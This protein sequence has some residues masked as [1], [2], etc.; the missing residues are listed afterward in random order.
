MAGGKAVVHDLLLDAHR[1]FLEGQTQ[2]HAHVAALAACGVAASGHAAEERAED[3]A[4][5]AETATEY[6]FEIDVAA[7]VR[8]CATGS[9][10]SCTGA[11]VVCALVGI[12]QDVVRL[13]ELLELLLGVRRL[14]H[15]GMELARLLT[16][17]LLYLVVRRIARHAY[18]FV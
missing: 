14:V 1:D 3:V 12:G 11:V 13:V 5:A 2:S 7:S 16:E 18:Y 15:V 9:S 17:R 6:V 4:H 10:R 8:T